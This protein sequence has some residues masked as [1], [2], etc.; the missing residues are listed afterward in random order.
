METSITQTRYGLPLIVAVAFH[1]ALLLWIP[2]SD[3]GFITPPEPTVKL[4]PLPIEISE[5]FRV[6]DESHSQASAKPAGGGHRSPA[7]DDLPR[8]TV[9][10]AVYIVD[11]E[12]TNPSVENE[13]HLP[14]GLPFGPGTGPEVGPSEGD[15]VGIGKL[16]RTPHAKVQP[17][18][19]YPVAMR[20]SGTEGRVVIEF[21]V[22]TAGNVVSATVHNATNREFEEAAVRAV[23][24]WR[25]E[26]GRRNGREVPFRMAVPLEFRLNDNA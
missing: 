5:V 20:A 26:P 18:P 22:D 23:M 17:S 7:L 1:A 9:E 13:T 15:P 14:N 24:R 2:K 19:Q 8:I 4:R 16:D 6:P 10:R 3:I 25:F 11:V 21:T 12:R